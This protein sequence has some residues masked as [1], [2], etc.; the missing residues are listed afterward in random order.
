MRN[1]LRLNRSVSTAAIYR[2]LGRFPLHVMRKVG[3]INYW[4][5]VTQSSDSLMFKIL[6]GCPNDNDTNFCKTW[7]GNIG[8]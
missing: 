4:F 2:E 1:N 3:I 5:K 6:F 8:F 7:A